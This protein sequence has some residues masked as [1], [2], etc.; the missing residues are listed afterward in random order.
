MRKN[1]LLLVALV[2]AT[3][4]S[5]QFYVSASG[6]LS[7]GSAGILMGTSLNDTKTEAENHYGSYG[8]GLN[9]QLMGGYFFNDMFGLELGVGYLHGS[10]Q[11]IDTYKVNDAGSI[12]EY[13]EGIAHGRAYGLNLSL[14]YKFNEKIYGKIGAITKLGGKTEAIFTKTTSTPLGPIIAEGVTDYHGRIPLGFTAT[15]GHKFKLNDNLNLFAELE[16]LGINVTRDNS[17]YQELLVTT[18]AIPAGVVGA[19]AVP[20]MTWTLGEAPLAHPVFGT[21]AAPSKITYVD[22]LSTTN[23]DPSKALSSVV[24]YSSFGINFGITY[25]FGNKEKN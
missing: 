15:I 20:S 3:S 25:N 8:E 23:T 22:N 7:M 6:G 21:I 1:L 18:P 14:V 19:S 11:T 16:Y 24:P 13:T 2:M 12:A 17:E 10:D 5:A 4:A 9:A